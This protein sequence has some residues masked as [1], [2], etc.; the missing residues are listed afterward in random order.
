MK[1]PQSLATVLE[2]ATMRRDEALQALGK[3]QRE[4]EQALLQMTQLESYV[5]DSLARWSQKASQGVNSS[6]LYHQ[7]Q[8][9]GRLDHAIEFQRGVLQRL[10][11]H[12]ERCQQQVM[13]AE[14]ELAGLNRYVDKREQTWRQ[15]EQRQ[16]QKSNDEMAANLHRQQLSPLSWKHTS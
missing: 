15:H 11:A 4:S 14:R 16:E 1:P 7:Q 5:Q 9:M 3:A 13:L 6:L 10:Q 2:V 8:F 12:I